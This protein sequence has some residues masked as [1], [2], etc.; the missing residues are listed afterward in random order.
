[1]LETTNPSR[2]P[3]TLEGAET[4]DMNMHLLLGLFGGPHTAK[5][6]DADLG[7]FTL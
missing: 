4:M 1:M 5:I 3:P 6:V 2:A 7:K